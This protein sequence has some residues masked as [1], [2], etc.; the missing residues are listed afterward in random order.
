M[1]EDKNTADNFIK[2]NTYNFS[3]LL[4]S[5]Q[6]IAQEYNISSIPVSIFIDKNRKYCT[7]KNWRYF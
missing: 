3:V 1:E 4:D 7:K 2:Q 5:D 6:S